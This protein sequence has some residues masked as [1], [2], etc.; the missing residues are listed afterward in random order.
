[1]KFILFATN[2]IIFVSIIFFFYFFLHTAKKC[3]CS[4]AVPSKQDLYHRG[5]FT[6]VTVLLSLTSLV[7]VRVPSVADPLP[8]GVRCVHMGRR[9]C[10]L[11]PGPL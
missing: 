5:H 11:L 6:G 9:G 4:R 1:M 7:T 10:A 8:G 2:L 3:T